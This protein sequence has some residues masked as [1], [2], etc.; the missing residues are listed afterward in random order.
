[1]EE[2]RGALEVTF[3]FDLNIAE[4]FPKRSTIKIC[5]ISPIEMRFFYTISHHDD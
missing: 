2:T 3:T 5:P 1:L 4:N